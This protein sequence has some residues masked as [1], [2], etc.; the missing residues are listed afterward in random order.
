MNAD[1]RILSIGGLGA[2][3]E[4]IEGKI[5]KAFIRE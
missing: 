2:I 5:F 4:D 3:F 1:G